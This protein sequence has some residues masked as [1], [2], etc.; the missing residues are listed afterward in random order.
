MS[1]DE[2]VKGQQ[3]ENTKQWERIR[4]KGVS[5]KGQEMQATW[6]TERA[7]LIEQSD[8]DYLLK[9]AGANEAEI[10]DGKITVY[11]STEKGIRRTKRVY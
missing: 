7:R 11:R 5:E 8:K 2:W 9:R 3:L 1:F 6:E 10:K 4:T